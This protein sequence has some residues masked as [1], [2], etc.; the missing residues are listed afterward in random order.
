MRFSHRPIRMSVNNCIKMSQRS[1]AV[2]Q[3]LQRSRLEQQLAKTQKHTAGYTHSLIQ[4]EVSNH[5][6]RQQAGSRQG[7]GQDTG[8]GQTEE[9]RE[10]NH[11][12]ELAR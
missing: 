12:Y 9:S 6:G 4:A 2:G 5:G 11:G 1:R 3:P 8:Q 10:V 7:C